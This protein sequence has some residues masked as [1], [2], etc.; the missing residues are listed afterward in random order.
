MKNNVLHEILTARIWN[1]RADSLHQY[2][3]AIE[4]NAL[5]RIVID[6]G[7]KEKVTH[8]LCG[9][10]DGFRNA[11]VVSDDPEWDK[12]YGRIKPDDEFINVICMHGPVT[13]GGG[14]C[15]YG[16]KEIRDQIMWSADQDNCL[17]HIIMIDTPGGSSWAKHDFKQAIDY[18]HA[19]GHKVIASIDGLCCSAGMCLAAMC[20]YIFYM[21]PAD[22]VGCI[23]TMAAFYA[24]PDGAVS[25]IDGERYVEVYANQ[26]PDKNIEFR[27]AAKGE[28][29]KL[30]AEITADAAEF[31]AI[32][33]AGRPNVTDEYLTGKTYRAE[34]VK[35]I[36]VDEQGTFDDAVR[37]ILS[38]Y[39]GYGGTKPYPHHAQG[40]GQE[41]VNST[42]VSEASP[43][44]TT[45]SEASPSDSNNNPKNNN[46]Q[47]GKNYSRIQSALG[48][49]AMESDNENA[50]FLNEEFADRLESTLEQGEQVR[51]ALNAKMEENKTLNDTIATLRSEKESEI[52]ALNETHDKAVAELEA[53]HAQEIADLN[54]A[55]ES[56]LTAAAESAKA[57][58]DAKQQTI[59][60]L[61]QEKAALEA[62]V[63]EQE[64]EIQKLSENAAPAPTP[65]PKNPEDSG[66]GDGEGDKGCGDKD[67]EV[68]AIYTSEMTR[69]EKRAAREQ[70]MKALRG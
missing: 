20:D 16:S 58:A 39:E 4:N 21:N 48:L 23:G 41:K 6:G 18:A 17:G 29:D 1:M 70:R 35:G 34:D 22:E 61:A 32:V 9:R 46:K 31:H 15:S 36:L 56:A 2:R 47:M 37:M 50:L 63:A 38:D 67:K 51:S 62:K 10:K 49:E 8:F 13:R 69:A 42:T 43:S 64:A 57:D 60:S 24:T 59:D 3:H 7:L 14:A 53:K 54:T 45:V 5:N 30:I 55:H 19:K 11:L 44:N 68:H 52:A 25:T 33:R 65:A 28:Y 40:E 26:S 66:S 12:R 27:D